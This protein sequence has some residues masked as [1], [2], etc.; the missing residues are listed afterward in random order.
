[1][2]QKGEQIAT[3]DHSEVAF[4][5]DLLAKDLRL[6]VDAASR[7][8]PVTDAVLQLARRAV[9]AGH[10]ALDYAAVVNDTEGSGPHVES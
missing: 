7:D 3:G 5:L 4:S 1:M 6:A 10:G 8:L 9:D 2:A